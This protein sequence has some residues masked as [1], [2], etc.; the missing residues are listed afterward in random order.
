MARRWQGGGLVVSV[1]VIIGVIIGV[2]VGVMSG[3]DNASNMCLQNRC[4]SLNIMYYSNTQ[5][6]YMSTDISECLMVP[7]YIG[8]DMR[9]NPAGYIR[10]GK[11]AGNPAGYIR[12]G[13]VAGNPGTPTFQKHATLGKVTCHTRTK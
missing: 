3:F 9:G 7:I 13:K 12:P 5:V 4:D 2:I 6:N 8:A 11:V 1:G 10:A